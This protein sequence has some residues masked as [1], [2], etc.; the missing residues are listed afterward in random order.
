MEKQELKQKW[1]ELYDIMASSGNP[2]NMILFGS[3]MKEMME[4]SIAADPVFAE[5]M[6][7]KLCAVK[8][9]NYLTQAE[10]EAIVA[11]MDPVPT[12]NKDL[13]ARQLERL[14]MPL[15][16]E[17][18]YNRWALYATMMMK[19]SD[20]RTTIA[21]LMGKTLDDVTP[22]EMTVATHLLAIDSLK[23]QDG[24]FDVRKYFD[25]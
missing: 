8:W 9:K 1:D 19:N 11:K 24:K 13:W 18:H 14:G 3:V 5:K 2:R 21:K 7:E 4:R 12:M 15:Y 17:P 20:D 6:I 16:E 25:V 23:D 10:A 22:D